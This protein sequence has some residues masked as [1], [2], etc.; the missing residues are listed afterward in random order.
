MGERKTPA[1]KIEDL[2]ARATVLKN[3]IA[4]L[5]VRQK[6]ADRKQDARRKIIIGGSILAEM[7]ADANFRA[8]VLKILKRRVT[9]K[10]DQETLGDFLKD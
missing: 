1:E 10:I 4:Q 9:R 8:T 7:Q 6:T 5:K 3:R 2:E